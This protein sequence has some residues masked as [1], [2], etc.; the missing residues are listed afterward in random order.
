MGSL[1]R[2][3]YWLVLAFPVL[4]L[5]L[6]PLPIVIFAL[7]VLVGIYIVAREKINPLTYPPLRL[8]SW[9]ALG[10]FAVM[11][12]SVVLSHE[13]GN[14]WRHLSRIS[15]FLL[16]PLVGAA[17]VYAEVPV[18][19]MIHFFKLGVIVAGVIAFGDYLLSNGSGRFSGMYN[20]NTF[21]DIAVVMLFVAV[22]NLSREET[23]EY[24]WS[25]ATVVAGVTAIALSGSRGSMLAMLLLIPVL[26]WLTRR[27]SEGKTKRALVV[28]TLMLFVLGANLF[29]VQTST[30]R[31]LN[32][33]SEIHRKSSS[34]GQRLQMYKAGW[35]AFLDAPVIGYGYHNCGHAAARYA[36]QDKSVQVGFVGRWHLHNI[37]ITD[38]VN[39]GLAGLLALLGLYFIPLYVLLK[40]TPQGVYVSGGIVLIIG[41]FLIG[42][43]H[44]QFGYEYETAFFVFMMVYFLPK[45]I[46]EKNT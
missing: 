34:A 1:R 38:M 43:T 29:L 21:G 25:L 37:F 9:L 11:A 8:F 12:V 5:A 3:A 14:D 2:V 45:S 24:R 28:S 30:A 16:A 39:A 32:I 20:P 15:Y 40:K 33:D 23:G 18:R 36:D 41:Y 6:K 27:G 19:K 10:Y 17:V 22:S 4:L 31:I 26:L 35:K 44:T 7:L 42:M 46:L 13:A